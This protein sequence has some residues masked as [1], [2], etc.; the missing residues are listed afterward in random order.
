LR[1]RFAS[2]DFD[3]NAKL[4]NCGCVD[5]HGDSVM[6]GGARA[7]GIAESSAATA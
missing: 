6:R 2:D 3:A 1:Q 4:L 5:G 7:D